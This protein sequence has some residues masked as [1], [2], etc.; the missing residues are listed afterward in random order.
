MTTPRLVLAALTVAF[1]SIA[2]ATADPAPM[3]SHAPMRALP[4]PSTRPL[5]A[6][7]AL[8]VDGRTGDDAGPGS[9][10]RPWKTIGAAISR[11]AP[12]D[13]LVLRGGTYYESVVVNASGKPGAPITIRSAPGELAILDGGLREFAESPGT[14][15]EPAPGGAPGEFRSKATYP[16]LSRRVAE[17]GVWLLGNF[18]DSMVPLHG[19]KFEADLRARNEYWN[20]VKD[21]AGT[22]IY[23]GPGIWLD[24]KT[25]RIH[26]R[27][28]HTT[29]KSQDN[30][31]GETDPRKVPLVI[32][33]D[34]SALV[35][36]RAHHVRIQDVVLRGS[37]V[38]TVHVEGASD[39]ELDGV[40]I[41][42]G[43]PALHVRATDRL[44]L[45][46]SALRGIAAPW[47]SRASMKYRGASPYLL[48][49]DSR[50]PQSRD[51][52][53]AYNELTDG[54][55]GIVIDSLKSLRFHHNLVD[56][57]ND[58]ALYLV[59]A[60]RQA[61]P[62]DIRIYENWISRAYSAL[63]FAEDGSPN[64]IGPGVYLYRN[65]FDLRVG[66]YGWIPQDE[67]GDKV[68]VELLASRMCGDH[69][70]PIWEPLFFYHNTV[71][72]AGKAVRDYYGLQMV[73]GMRGTKRRL[74]NNVF[75]QVDGEPGLNFAGAAGTD[76]QV[77]ANLMWG[78]GAKPTGAAFFAAFRG[79]PLFE[80]SKQQYAPG[81]GARDQFADPRFV[82]LRDFEPEIDLR[83]Q[84]G[85]PAIDAGIALP[86]SW[87]DSLRA[88]DKGK[89]DLGALPLGAPRLRVGPSAAPVPK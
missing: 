63:A 74:F 1:S 9:P 76:L 16:A 77:D 44:R 84:P 65:V 38:H 87:P 48:V 51:W 82:A 40:T 64:Q 33:A 68:P 73:M 89:P 80:S 3:R 54:H 52:E 36:D 4:S 24:R 53:I 75:V 6:G 71:I 86:A 60:P 31:R 41:Y 19:Y 23:V 12:G 79:S 62:E 46:R 27:L 14:A 7:R 26:V 43:A 56:N 11:L 2:P 78:L 45:V 32:G 29:L 34:R 15:W 57:F 35:I 61:V 88:A 20:V 66:T 25:H 37:A 47:S 83:I 72:N 49:A 10:A 17:R 58:D 50:L 18:A 21:Q 8:Y 81:W 55:D 67:T 22:G 5:A 39:L 59:L 70:S 30:Y 28:A 42:G 85:S 13:T 69:G